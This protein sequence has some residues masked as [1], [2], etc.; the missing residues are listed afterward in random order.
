M[1]P[2]IVNSF[3]DKAKCRQIQNLSAKLWQENFLGKCL[4]LNLSYFSF[5]ILIFMETTA[6]GKKNCS[7]R[8]KSFLFIRPFCH[9]QKVFSWRNLN[10]KAKK[11]EKSTTWDSLKKRKILKC[12][13][14]PF[15][16]YVTWH[17]VATFLTS[18]RHFLYK[19]FKTCRL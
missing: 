16:L 7:L 11:E 12:L 14:G 17:F 15:K 13:L 4:Q 1:T 10:W 8:K 9:L 3:N 5:S 19:F 6:V 2:I 18:V